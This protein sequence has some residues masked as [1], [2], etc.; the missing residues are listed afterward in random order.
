[1][2]KKDNSQTVIANILLAH[3]SR[4]ESWKKP[5]EE[6]LKKCVN[7][8]PEKKFCLCYLELCDPKLEEV[9]KYLTDNYPKISTIKVYPLFLSA[10]I[11]VN[12]DIKDILSNLQINYPKIK[13]YLN[14]VIGKNIIVTNAI[15]KVISS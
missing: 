6:L 11:H 5:F 3:G 9:V 7:G 10:G 15:Y 13:F 4:D 8:S 14:D 1:M 12:K 2:V